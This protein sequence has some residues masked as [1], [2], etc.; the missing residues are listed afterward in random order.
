MKSDEMKQP[1]ACADYPQIRETEWRRRGAVIRM[2]IRRHSFSLR[3]LLVTEFILDKTYGYQLDAVAIPDLGYFDDI[4]GI[5]DTD[6]VKVLK[7]LHRMRIIYI[8]EHRGTGKKL[9]SVNPNTEAWKIAP[10]TERRD[11]QRAI[12]RLRE[13]NGLTPVDEFPNFLEL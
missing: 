10:R 13:W 7:A 9:Y 3:E 5:E 4:L 11:M 2:E 1:A 6:A 8:R 12:N